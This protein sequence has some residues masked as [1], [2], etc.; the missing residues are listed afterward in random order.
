MDVIEINRLFTLFFTSYVE[1]ISN[2]H[3]NEHQ[4]CSHFSVRNINEHKNSTTWSKRDKKYLCFKKKC[5]WW[6]ATN[7]TV[8]VSVTE[9]NEVN[10]LKT[11]RDYFDSSSAKF[12]SPNFFVRFFKRKVFSRRRVIVDYF[13]PKISI[14]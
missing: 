2:V 7:D 13:L 14:N 8:K 10:I 9:E 11:L 5:A 3:L 12:T 6:S 4:S 1:M